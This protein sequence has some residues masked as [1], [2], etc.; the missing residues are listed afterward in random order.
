MAYDLN[1]P[2]HKIVN[3]VMKRIEDYLFD[4][5]VKVIIGEQGRVIIED[6]IYDYNAKLSEM[7]DTN[8]KLDIENQRLNAQLVK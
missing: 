1:Q 4:N 8:G 6:L 3:Q 7:Y 2:E 5:G